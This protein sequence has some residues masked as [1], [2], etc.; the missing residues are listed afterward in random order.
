MHESLEALEARIAA[1][2]RAVPNLRPECEKTIVWHP[3]HR[4]ATAPMALVY[5]H[6]FSASRMETAPFCDRLAARLNANVFYTRLAGHGCDGAAMGQCGADD[7]IRDGHEALEIAAAIGERVVLVGCSTGASLATWLASR[8]VA[9]VIDGLVLVAPNFGPRAFGSFLLD[10]YFAAT[11]TEWILGAERAPEVANE[12]HA[13]YW[14]TRYPSRALLAM[15]DMVRRARRAD[16]ERIGIPV[17]TFF[18]P[19]DQV[20]DARRIRRALARIPGSQQ[21]C[22]ITQDVDDPSGH[23]ICGDAFSPRTTA[24]CV[25]LAVNFLGHALAD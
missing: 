3:D 2:E 6:G 9:G 25:E 18:N 5:V 8:D 11:L 24:T 4:H 19:A 12:A 17:V 1:A 15:A 13:R 23:V 22:E 7:W 14:T 16:L 21:V 10:W 20:V